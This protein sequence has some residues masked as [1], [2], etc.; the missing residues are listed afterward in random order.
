MK[1]INILILLLSSISSFVHSREI[2]VC[3]NNDNYPF[4]FVNDNGNPD[5]F[6]I[7]LIYAIG[8]EAAIT[9]NF[10]DESW[11]NLEDQLFN[12]DV[13]LFLIYKNSNTKKDF[14]IYSYPLY[15]SYFALYT[16][17]N[18]NGAKNRNLKGETLILSSGDSSIPLI[19]E[20]Y[21]NSEI[22]KTKSWSDSLSSLSLEYGDYAIITTIQ[23]EIYN[24]E[25]NSSIQKLDG[26]ELKLPYYIATAK[27]N[28]ALL[29]DINNGISNIKASGEFD[30]IYKKWFGTTENILL[31]R[32]YG[33]NK[34]R[35]YLMIPAFIAVLIYLLVRGKKSKK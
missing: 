8:R 31:K 18:F 20:N 32:D 14:I 17:N 27:W 10:I 11:K 33:I 3:F 4:E 12:R 13:D 24:R 29:E 23:G 26:F 15:Y 25:L 22:I 2:N 7:D 9:L 16:R 1:K 34:I 5:G 6:T 28:K 21:P 35:I 19:S 30:S